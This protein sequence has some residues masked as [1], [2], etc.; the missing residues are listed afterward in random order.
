M[1]MLAHSVQTITR[2]VQGYRK[3]YFSAGSFF[4]SDGFA[5]SFCEQAHDGRLI[6]SD[7]GKRQLAE[8]DWTC[9]TACQKVLRR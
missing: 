9:M 6:I 5:D 4:A 2:W 8:R 7:D 3:N 1:C